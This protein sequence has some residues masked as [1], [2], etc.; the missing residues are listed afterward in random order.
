MNRLI[1]ASLSILTL[2]LT[3]VTAVKAAPQVGC[4]AK[5]AIATNSKIAQ[6]V[7]TPFE[8]VSRAY[9]GDYRLEGIPGFGSFISES[10]NG[11]ITAK[12]LVQA[13]I[14]AKELSPDLITDRSYLSGIEQHLF[15][16]GK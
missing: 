14:D 15:S 9:Q 10:H 8:L 4:P 12:V 11:R 2:S 16:V 13:A 7:I 5:V 1:V 6:T 3:T